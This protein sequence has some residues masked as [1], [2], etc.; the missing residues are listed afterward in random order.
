MGNFCGCG[1]RNGPLKGVEDLKGTKANGTYH[2]PALQNSKVLQEQIR[3]GE[4]TWHRVGSNPDGSISPCKSPKNVQLNRMRKK[5]AVSTHQNDDEQEDTCDEEE[6]IQSERRRVHS[7]NEST[8][9]TEDEERMSSS[10]QPSSPRKEKKKKQRYGRRN[11]RANSGK[12]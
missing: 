11:Y 2:P 1:S 3:K 8:V 7:A 12:R 10:S 5:H 9:S 4:A 6:Y